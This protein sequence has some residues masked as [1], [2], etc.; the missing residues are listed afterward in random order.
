MVEA[1]QRVAATALF[2]GRARHLSW[3]FLEAA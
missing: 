3:P 2:F 1:G